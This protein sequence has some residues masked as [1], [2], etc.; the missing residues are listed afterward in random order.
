VL[1]VA[2]APVKSY[3]FDYLVIA[4]I[5]LYM[6]LFLNL[7]ICNYYITMTQTKV[8]FMNRDTEA[9]LQWFPFL[10]VPKVLENF[11]RIN[12]IFN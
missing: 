6:Y 2:Y 10:K 3:C 11:C 12:A 4:K 5:A 9:V 7:L 8:R 1:E